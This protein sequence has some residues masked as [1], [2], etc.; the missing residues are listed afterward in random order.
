MSALAAAA[1]IAYAFGKL[2]P[3][4]LLHATRAVE[5]S[6]DQAPVAHALLAELAPA[7][8][9]ACPRLFVIPAQ[10]P[11]GLAVASQRGGIVAVTEGVFERLDGAQLRGVLAILV[12]SLARRRARVETALAALAIVFAPLFL[13][14]VAFV[15]LGVRGDRWYEV[16]RSA[17][18]LVGSET[19]ADTLEKLES[20]RD[21]RVQLPSTAGACLCCVRPGAPSGWSDRAL[22]TQPPVEIRAARL[23]GLSLHPR[24]LRRSGPRSPA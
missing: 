3:L 11:N 5:A 19:I 18:T 12:A 22:A 9:I 21:E 13:P 8:R 2:G 24:E 1:F 14:S 23:R 10:Q 15:R 6:M 7:A 16:D 4:L 20:E 17:A